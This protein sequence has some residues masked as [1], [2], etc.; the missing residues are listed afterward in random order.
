MEGAAEASL[1]VDAAR[2]IPRRAAGQPPFSVVL[3]RT[4][5]ERHVDPI[6]RFPAVHLDRNFAQKGRIRGG[7]SLPR[8]SL[9]DGVT[10]VGKHRTVDLRLL[11]DVM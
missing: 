4:N 3:N 6:R 9:R 11:R 1:V 5:L 2:V 7:L 10:I 8:P